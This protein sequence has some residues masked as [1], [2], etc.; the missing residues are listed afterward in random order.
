V[1]SAVRVVF[2]SSFEVDGAGLLVALA[3]MLWSFLYTAGSLNAT[4]QTIGKAVLGVMVVRS[5]GARVN[6]RR[7]ALRT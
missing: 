6:V 2:R 4:G 5:D 3:F 1:Q 7:A